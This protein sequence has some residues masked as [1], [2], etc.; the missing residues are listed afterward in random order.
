MAKSVEV[1]FK[2]GGVWQEISVANFYD[3]EKHHTVRVKGSIE[4]LTYAAMRFPDGRIYD[5]ILNCW[6]QQ[7]ASVDHILFETVPTIPLSGAD[8]SIQNITLRGLEYSDGVTAVV[9]EMARVLNAGGRLKIEVPH[10]PSVLAVGDPDTK[11]FFNE[12]TFNH[13]H[14]DGKYP[15]FI[16]YAYN[17]AD[18]ILQATLRK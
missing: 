11:H 2:E 7:S 6:R 9:K 14:G 17:I 16:G 4:K 8:N 15:L 1:C 12:H 3:P 5:K 18:N 10:F 13:F